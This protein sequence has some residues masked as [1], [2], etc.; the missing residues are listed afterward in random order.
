MGWVTGSAVY[1]VIWWLV[2]FII[3]P[4]GARTII[5]T[6]DVE[7]GQDAGAPKRPRLLLKMAVTTVVAGVIFAGFYTVVESGMISFR[8]P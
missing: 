5:D 6:E 8:E 3:L 2:L 7:K 4:V 1:L